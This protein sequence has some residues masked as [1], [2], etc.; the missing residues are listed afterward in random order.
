M[1]SLCSRC[2]DILCVCVCET[3]FSRVCV[4]V[5]ACMCVYYAWVQFFYVCVGLIILHTRFARVY[6]CAGSRFLHTRIARVCVC[7][8][9]SENDVGELS[10]DVVEISPGSAS[11]VLSSAKPG[12]GIDQLLDSS[13]ETYWQSDGALPHSLT[14]TFYKKTKLTHLWIQLNYPLD[15]SYT[16]QQISVRIG[17]G[18]HDL[19][20]IQVVDFRE[21]DGW[22]KIPLAAREE[23]ITA[24]IRD[25]SFGGAFE[26]IRVW[27]I[28]IAILSNH[29]NGR[30][31]HV[32]QV[33]LFGPR[34][35]KHT[36]LTPI[37]HSNGV[38]ERIDTPLKT[39]EMLSMLVIR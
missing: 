39:P 31:T 36:T 17:M 1:Y 5:C 10:K 29:Q 14:V 13:S 30:D 4:C 15:E 19:Q 24:D 32:R 7:Y 9:M 3:L 2:V 25:K 28:Q 20:E 11:W 35:L 37:V 22:I 6:V 27:S 23:E 8:S 12:N 16:P 21:P 34:T 18:Y 33:K 26:F 38:M